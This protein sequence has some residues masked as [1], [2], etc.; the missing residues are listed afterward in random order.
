M[1]EGTLERTLVLVKPDGVKRGLMGKLLDRFELKGLKIVAARL[2]QVP[3]E[4]AARHYAEHEGKP[5]YPGLVQHITS[6]PVLALALEGRSA[7][8]VTRL[9]TGATNP[10]T[11][12]PGTIRGD[13]ALAITP[14]IIHASDSP[15]SA[16]RELGLYF[17]AEDYVAYTRSDEKFL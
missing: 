8:A 10:Q 17:R 3:P 5:F 2:L 7:I 6:G 13:Y 11:A 14:N 4:L 9:L 16:E 15:A 12:A 1:A